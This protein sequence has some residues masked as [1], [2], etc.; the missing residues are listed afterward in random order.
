MVSLATGSAGYFYLGS[1]KIDTYELYD[2]YICRD[3]G[4]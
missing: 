2:E 4:R 1:V 3:L